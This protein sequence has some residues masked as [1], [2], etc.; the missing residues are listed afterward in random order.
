MFVCVHTWLFL[1][2]LH[3][4]VLSQGFASLWGGWGSYLSETWSG[5]YFSLGN[6]KRSLWLGQNIFSISVETCVFSVQKLFHKYSYR[7]PKAIQF[8]FSRAKDF[9]SFFLFW[10]HFLRKGAVRTNF[11]VFPLLHWHSIKFYFSRFDTRR[12]KTIDYK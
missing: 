12:K 6:G 11:I 3:L 8:I 5:A 4:K 9:F 2:L 7:I 10:L 1:R